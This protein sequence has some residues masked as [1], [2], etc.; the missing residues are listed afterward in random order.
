MKSEKI[1]KS[2]KNVYNQIAH[3]FSHSRIYPWEELKVFIPYIKDGFKVLDLGCG[4][5]R[6]IKSLEEAHDKYHY[7]GV[8]FS[9][10]L[11]KE[12]KRK[13]PNHIFI[14]AD[15]VD[16]DF[17]PESF[18]MVFMI[19]SFHHLPTRRE[20][21]ELLYKIN[22]WLKPGGYLFMSNWNLWQKKYMKYTLEKFWSKH[23]WNDFFIPW[24][25]DKNNVQWRFYHSFTTWELVWLLKKTHFKLQPEGVYKTKWNINAFVSKKR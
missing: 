25:S 12:A 7:L 10:G 19:A 1:K 13:F 17:E 14:L 15:M 8:D 21:L 9:E 24:R 5:G 23:S 4:N 16:L 6:L 18:D 3:D 20:R 11:I 2:L 22:K